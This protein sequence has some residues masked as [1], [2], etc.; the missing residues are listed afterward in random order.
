[1]VGYGQGLVGQR[2]GAARVIDGHRGSDDSQR[3]GLTEALDA[4]SGGKRY[5]RVA[6]G[7]HGNDLCQPRFL[8]NGII[9]AVRD[10]EGAWSGSV[11]ARSAAMPDKDAAL[12][13][14]SSRWSAMSR[15]RSVSRRAPSGSASHCRGNASQSLRLPPAGGVKVGRGQSDITVTAS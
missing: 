12:S 15:A 10:G 11:L 13:S 4:V 1:M 14:G 3:L 9:H 7:Q 5:V 8:P 2:T 6:L